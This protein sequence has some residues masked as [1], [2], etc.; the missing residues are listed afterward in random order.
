MAAC[1]GD[2]PCTRWADLIN[3]FTSACEWMPLRL[4]NSR[5]VRNGC[6]FQPQMNCPIQAMNP[7]T[8]G[9]VGVRLF[10]NLAI[11]AATWGTD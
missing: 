5:I 2:V 3:Q 7:G 10:I 6:D 8:N 1:T 9:K 4:T 11:R